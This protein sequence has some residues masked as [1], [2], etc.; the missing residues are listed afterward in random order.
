LFLLCVSV[1]AYSQQ[2]TGNVPNPYAVSTYENSSLYWKTAEAGACSIR[3]K[4]VKDKTWKVGME[5]VYDTRHGEYRGSILHLKP[6]TEYQAELSSGGAKTKIT[7]KTRN[8]VFPIG[9][10]TILP[11]GESHKTVV[12]T[13]SGTPDAYH[14]VTVPANSMSVL[15]LQNASDHGIIVD[16][17]YVIIRG[18]EIR[19]ARVHGIRI[20]GGKHDIVVEQCNITFWGRLGGPVSYGNSE[21]NMDSGIYALRGTWNLTIQRNLIEGPRGSSNDWETGHPAGPQGVSFL[22]SLGGN[23]IRYNDIVTTENH[24]F[25]DAIGGGANFSDAGNMNRDSDIYGNFIRGVFDDAIECEGANMNVRIWGNY[26]DNFFVGVATAST[27]FG[28]VYIYRNVLAS[29]R[30]SERNSLGWNMFKVGDRGEFKGGRRYYLHNTAVQPDGSYMSVTRCANCVAWN[31]VFDVPGHSTREPDPTSDFDYN[32]GGENEAHAVSLGRM[33]A[34]TRLFV[35][36]H[37]LEFYPQLYVRGINFGKQPTMFGEKEKIITDPVV[38]M[39]NPMIDGG[40]RIPGFND[41][42]KGAAPD[43]GAFE[44]GAPPLEYGRR[45]YYNSDEGWCAWERF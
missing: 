41:D 20:N 27:T 15:N 39:R 40:K 3:Y 25:N 42:F 18:V 21:G 31:N 7:F 26:I 11:A 35:P 16:A 34:G 5:L 28:P 30:R 38:Q 19:N 45:A 14:L 33:P 36:S 8:D 22:Q 9:K 43:V 1:S 37:K 23:V 32:F 4:E 2:P 29:S 13:E 44:V 24:A 6:N 12:I 10:T 17:D